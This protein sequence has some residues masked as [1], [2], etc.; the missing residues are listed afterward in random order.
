MLGGPLGEH[1]DAPV[2][3]GVAGLVH[4][5]HR[6][7]HRPRLLGACGV[8]EIGDGPAA[9]LLP[10]DR[11]V[12]ADL[13]EVVGGGSGH[14]PKLV[15]SRTRWSPCGGEAADRLYRNLLD[16]FA[17]KAPDQDLPGIH[18]AESPGAEV[19]ECVLVQPADGRPVGALHVVG[20][21]L[22]PGTGVDHGLPRKEQVAVRLGR[23]GPDRARRHHHL[24]VEHGA[25]LVGEHVLEE[26]AARGV[27]GGVDDEGVL[28]GLRVLHPQEETV[29]FHLAA[30]GAEDGGRVGPGLPA[31]E[32][33]HRRV[34]PGVP[35]KLERHAARVGDVPGLQFDADV[36]QLGVLAEAAEGGRV[37]PARGGGRTVVGF[38]DRQPAAGTDFD[39]RARV[40]HGRVAGV[41]PQRI[42]KD[43]TGVFVAPDPDPEPAVEE[44]GVQHLEGMA[45]SGVE[46]RPGAVRLGPRHNK[47]PVVVLVV[48]RD[49]GEAPEGQGGPG[50]AI[51]RVQRRSVGEQNPLLEFRGPLRQLVGLGSQ[52]RG[53]GI[54]PVGD[55]PESV[56]VRKPPVLK[57]RRGEPTGIEELLDRF[58]S[59]KGVPVADPDRNLV[60]VVR[61]GG[62]DSRCHHDLRPEPPPASRSPRPRAGARV[63][64]LPTRRSG[65]PGARAPG[66]ERCG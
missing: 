53:P 5:V 23:V 55:A 13:V 50:T 17:G 60:A 66:R 29:E 26:L 10:E 49:G 54:P 57:P 45:E 64:A 14:L 35:L 34:D 63:P 37:R 21:D 1:V 56:Q 3:V 4:V 27:P 61:L 33:E 41:A 32:R 22:E 58:P 9:D 11:E 20:V 8:V 30:F 51:L 65:P 24:A 7:E 44:P 16:D 36:A 39:D 18:A 42:E 12:G 52:D 48:G 47:P 15:H 46:V 6:V 31:G 40:E 43:R 28:V 25:R 38:D 59:P 19:E 62:R 2:D